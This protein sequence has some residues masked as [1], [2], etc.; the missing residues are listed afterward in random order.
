MDCKSAL[1]GLEG[2]DYIEGVVV[3]LA[4]K[5]EGEE[6]MYTIQYPN[7]VGVDGITKEAVPRS[8]II[9]QPVWPRKRKVTKDELK[10]A[11]ASESTFKSAL[12]RQLRI[13]QDA[14]DLSEFN[15]A[16]PAGTPQENPGP[17]KVSVSVEGKAETRGSL[18]CPTPKRRL[19]LP[20]SGKGG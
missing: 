2:G 6:D 1:K 10:K 18:T 15:C 14:L 19:N 16:P 20:S 9:G 8:R 3:E 5:R 17:R 7:E 11:S 4:G 13:V 12:D